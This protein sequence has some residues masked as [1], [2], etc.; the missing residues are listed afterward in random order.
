MGSNRYL[1]YGLLLAAIAFFAVGVVSLSKGFGWFLLGVSVCSF[2]AFGTLIFKERAAATAKLRTAKLRTAK[3]NQS[4]SRL[5]KAP[6]QKPASVNKLVDPPTKA[7]TETAKVPVAKP[8]LH[9]EKQE[10]PINR[11]SLHPEAPILHPR[12]QDVTAP[13]KTPASAKT[14]P[15]IKSPSPK[16]VIP[17]K[18]SQPTQVTTSSA[19]GSVPTYGKL[20]RRYLNQDESD[21]FAFF[22]YNRDK[23][24]AWDAPFAR[25]ANI[26]KTENWNFQQPKYQKKSENF[27]I[28]LQYLNHTFL[29]LQAE[30][31]I[32]FESLQGQPYAFF[33][34]G[35]QTPSNKDIFATFR[36]NKK[37]ENSDDYPDW[38]FRKWYDD[39]A[40]ELANFM[41][42]PQPASYFRH[43]SE[44]TFDASYDL[45]MNVKHVIRDNRTR[46]PKELQENET[47]AT[48]ALSG[49]FESLKKRCQRN[50]A[51]AVPYWYAHD[52]KVQL[53]LPLY[54]TDPNQA[55][56]ALVADKNETGKVYRIK[57]ILTLDMAYSN[58]RLLRKP[59]QRWLN[60]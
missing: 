49:A 9:P 36:P 18:V 50:D 2:L 29:R 37:A 58:A 26:A 55:D 23:G 3:L 54:I 5:P 34:T 47:L 30:K 6:V 59:S 42:L 22:Y 16:K 56:A 14:S 40:K 45:V 57:T 12:N 38:F 24:D 13:N 27:P 4:Q 31:K 20:F 53:L 52:Q 15:K 1:K 21:A 33:N 60:P 44:K 17:Q 32:R 48:S 39:Y 7:A 25:L 19:A 46:L 51:A 41:P 8:I 10:S 11:P 43:Q 28:L 35:L